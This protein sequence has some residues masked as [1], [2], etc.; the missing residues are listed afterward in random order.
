MFDRLRGLLYETYCAILPH[1]VSLECDWLPQPE[2]AS[3]DYEQ[4]RQ[5]KRFLKNHPQL[6]RL[7]GHFYL[8]YYM[9]IFRP[10]SWWRHT[11]A[12]RTLLEVIE[13]RRI[14]EISE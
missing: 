4:R 12:C 10:V 9:P 2:P 8:G 7:H 6:A 14:W 11:T 5:F 1:F 13:L 3:L